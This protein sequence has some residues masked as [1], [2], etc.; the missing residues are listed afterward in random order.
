M[1]VLNEIVRT[2]HAIRRSHD[3]DVERLCFE[4]TRSEME[5][6]LCYLHQQNWHTSCSGD[7]VATTD[8]LKIMGIRVREVKP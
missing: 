8:G 2:I 1:T 6:L 7:V 3:C 5:D 4:I